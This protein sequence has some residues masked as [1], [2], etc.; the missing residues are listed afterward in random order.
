MRHF[1]TVFMLCAVGMCQC[2]CRC[3]CSVCVPVPVQVQLLV[4]YI[5]LQVFSTIVHVS[6]FCVGM[7]MCRCRCMSKCICLC[8][9]WCMSVAALTQ[10]F[11][12]DYSHVHRFFF[13]TFFQSYE[14]RV[15]DLFFFFFLFFFLSQLFLNRNFGHYFE[16]ITRFLGPL[17]WDKPS[18]QGDATEGPFCSL[19]LPQQDWPIRT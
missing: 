10:V 7:C 6:S 3:M 13:S 15:Y 11:I 17:F 5:A 9:C 16:F 18:V 8:R 14:L 4:Q 1:V 12:C 19:V 2:M